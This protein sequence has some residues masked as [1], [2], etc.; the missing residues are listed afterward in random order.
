VALGGEIQ[1]AHA[2]ATDRATCLA[3]HMDD[4]STKPIDPVRLRQTLEKALFAQGHRRSDG[5]YGEPVFD[6]GRLLE[7]TG[8]DRSFAL[9]LIE[10]FATSARETL[11]RM[12]AALAGG[13]H[14]DALR[15]L[16]HTLKG[17]AAAV[18]AESVAL[19]ATAME[20]AAGTG[21]A[22]T[23]IRRLRVALDRTLAA[24]ERDGWRPAAN[25][26]AANAEA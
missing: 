10:V 12:E 21:E 20:R 14:A 22:I 26:T 25:S 16:A 17:S 1:P 8:H 3:A 19:A 5:G 13:E 11:Q 15:G 9:E 18:T 24:W 7:R 23:A 2:L 6:S 4:Y